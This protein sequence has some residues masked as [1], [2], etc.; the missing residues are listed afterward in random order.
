[1]VNGY[2]IRGIAVV[3]VVA[4]I[5]VGTSPR[6]PSVAAGVRIRLADSCVSRL[7]LVLLR[8]PPTNCVDLPDGHL[9]RGLLCGPAWDRSCR[10]CERWRGGV[11]EGI[12]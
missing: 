12:D 8:N 6:S 7:V 10:S 2:P 3:V 5:L 9:T 4:L 11:V 1:M